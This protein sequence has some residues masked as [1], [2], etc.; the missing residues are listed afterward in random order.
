MSP[1]FHSGSPVQKMRSDCVVQYTPKTKGSL[2][3]SVSSKVAALY[4]DAIEAQ[5]VATLSDLGISHG[6]LHIDDYGALPFVIQA[7]IEAAVKSAHPDI[8]DLSLPPLGSHKLAGGSR[9]RL[10]RS[11]LYIPGVQPKM[12]VNALVHQADGIILDLEDSVAPGEK[13]SA[14][15]IVRNALRVLDFGGSER[16]VR[17]NQGDLGL[18]DIAAIVPEPVQLIL[19]PKAETAQ[20]VQQVEA[21][22]VEVAKASGRKEPVY[23]MPI[24]ESALGIENAY[25]IA[26]ASESIAALAIGLEDYTADMGVQRTTEGAESAYARGALVNAARAAG[27]QA[28][29]TVF[30]DVEDMEGLA[31]SARETHALGYDGMGAIH[32]RQVPVIHEN[33]APSGDEIEKAKRIVL[34]FDEAQAQGLGVVALGSK[35]IDRPVVLR[36]QRT[37]DLAITSGLLKKRWKRAGK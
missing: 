27:L 23:L 9:D 6:Q 1:T 35:M 20:Q 26:T 14:R 34:A 30:S 17:I 19:I 2:A 22:I 11:R 29:A 37:V 36:A 33:F 18:A 8:T 32:P 3:I 31:R 5:A 13:V 7:R 24:L 25:A 28:I 15:L 21:R 12:M 4:G 16:M 10:R